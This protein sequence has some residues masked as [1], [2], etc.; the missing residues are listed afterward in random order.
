M[1]VIIFEC[2]DKGNIKNGSRE[3]ILLI[4]FWEKGNSWTIKENIHREE[5]IPQLGDVD[6]KAGKRLERDRWLKSK[7]HTTYRQFE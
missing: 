5:I 6:V 7:H 1:N 2:N 3:T 4:Y